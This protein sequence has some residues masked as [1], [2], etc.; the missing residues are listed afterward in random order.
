MSEPT[1]FSV[2]IVGGGPVGM[3]L[4]MNLDPFGVASVLINTDP[5]TRWHRRGGTPNARTME[6]YRP[7]GLSGRLRKLGMPPD[8]PTDV[9]YFTRLNGWELA[10]I[11]MP[12]EAE[13]MRAV[14][15]AAA[16]DQVPEPILRAS[17]MYVE[18]AV[19]AQLPEGRHIT[20][21]YGWTCGDWR[22]L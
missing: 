1:T 2:A 6:H 21:R 18:A 12:S 16:T 20:L 13:K 8:H 4:A 10:R 11:A 5:T 17:Q 19:F 22:R 9:S 3:M 7:L 15:G 14:A